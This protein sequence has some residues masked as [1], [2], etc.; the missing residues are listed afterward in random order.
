M[1]QGESNELNDILFF[2]T[3]H[4]FLPP[5]L[6][7]G[8][9]TFKGGFVSCPIFLFTTPKA[10]SRETNQT[11]DY[12]RVHALARS[13]VTPAASATSCRQGPLLHAYMHNNR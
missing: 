11:E 8:N 10:L 4:Y 3:L 12:S 9:R 7:K 5:N 13:T 6:F 1:L 2:I